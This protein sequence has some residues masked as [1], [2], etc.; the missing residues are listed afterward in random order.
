MYG[1][2]GHRHFIEPS[3]TGLMVKFLMEV[4]ERMGRK[5]NWVHL[6]VPPRRDDE[7]YFEPLMRVVPLLTKNR[8]H[9]D[10]GLV[11]AAD[12]EGTRRRA[13]SA[14]RV[15]SEGEGEDEVELRWGV[16]TECGMGRTPRGELEGIL[17]IMK[18]VASLVR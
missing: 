13:E 16:A 2:I 18:S 17:E 8:T 4:L 7:A 5:V 6:P 1:D 15:L 14:K 11:H 3:N 12:E 9:L 10:L